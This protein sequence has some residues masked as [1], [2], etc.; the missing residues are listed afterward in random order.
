[1][2]E[3]A[4]ST[5]IN[6]H[7]IRSLIRALKYVS[8]IL[9]TEEAYTVEEYKHTYTHTRTQVLINEKLRSYF[10]KCALINMNQGPSNFLMVSNYCVFHFTQFWLYLMQFWLQFFHLKRTVFFTGKTKEN[11]KFQYEQSYRSYKSYIEPIHGS[12]KS[13]LGI[14]RDYFISYIK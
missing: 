11:Q 9:Q 7:N 6:I 14:T 12:Q 4:R 3:L 5:Q 13:L 2:K 1:M 8:D 10:V